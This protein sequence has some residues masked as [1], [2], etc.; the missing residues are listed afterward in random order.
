MI[1]EKENKEKDIK[2][3]EKKIKEQEDII[4]ILKQNEEELKEK[5]ENDK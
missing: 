5:N 2:L 4:S 3:K 1:K